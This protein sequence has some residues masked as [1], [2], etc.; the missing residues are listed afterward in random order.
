MFFREATP[1]RRDGVSNRGGIS[2]GVRGVGP[3]D[4]RGENTSDPNP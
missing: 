4:P 1:W 2:D 3:A